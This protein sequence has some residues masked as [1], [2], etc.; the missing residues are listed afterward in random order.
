MGEEES[1][2]AVR[3]EDLARVSR[4]YLAPARWITIVVQ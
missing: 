3:P 1:L 2:R 4:S